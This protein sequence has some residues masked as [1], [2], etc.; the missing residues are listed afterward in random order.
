MG[1]FIRRYNLNELAQFINVI[2][3]EMSIVEPIPEIP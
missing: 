1:K 3:G 2:K